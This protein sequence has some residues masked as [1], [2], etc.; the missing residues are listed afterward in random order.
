M[1]IATQIHR[2]LGL[3]HSRYR[4]CNV[5]AGVTDYTYVKLQKVVCDSGQG[6]AWSSNGR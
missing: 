4:Q 2:H 6:L 5:N 1:C 3:A